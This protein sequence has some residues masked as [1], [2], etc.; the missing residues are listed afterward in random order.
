MAQVTL[1]RVGQPALPDLDRQRG[2]PWRIL[3][4]GERSRRAKELL[5][6]VGAD[7]AP[8]ALVRD[9]SMPQQQLVEIASALGGDAKVL[10]LDE[11]SASLSDREVENLFRV[12]HELKSHGVGMIYISHRLEELPQI[13][14][15][16]TVLR[17]G[18]VIGTEQIAAMGARPSSAGLLL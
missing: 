1:E 4:W 11:P 9:L 6:R 16:V 17:D 15:R 13:A 14:D 12:V 18:K 8:S 10:I 7:I 3:R 2:G 5:H